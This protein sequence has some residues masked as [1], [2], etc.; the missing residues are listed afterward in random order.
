M[1]KS[2]S[3]DRKSL[4]AGLLAACCAF[5]PT[6]HAQSGAG[7]IQGTVKDSTGAVVPNCAVHVVNQATAVA[8]DT[9]SNGAGFMLCL[10]CSPR[11][12]TVTFS[13]PGMKKYQQVLELQDAKVAVLDPALSVGDL[14]EQIT[15]TGETVQ[16]ATYDSGVVS[17]ELD[18]NRIDQLPQNGR[19]VLA[20]RRTPSPASKPVAPAPTVSWEKPWSIRWTA[21]P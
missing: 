2:F 10:G 4:L 17:T 12:Y 15:V 1:I 7:V 19:N 16:L 14:A 3:L 11:V 9:K 8:N 18:A 13:A 21:L 20:S 5:A 6:V